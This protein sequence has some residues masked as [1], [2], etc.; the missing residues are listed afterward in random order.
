MLQLQKYVQGVLGISETVPAR[1]HFKDHQ[2]H[3]L[4]L[5]QEQ[6]LTMLTM[7]VEASDV[8]QGPLVTAAALA[9]S[10]WEDLQ[11]LRRCE[12]AGRD[13]H[14]LDKREDA[15]NFC[16]LPPAEEKLMTAQRGKGK[17][18]GKG[19]GFRS[20]QP[21][22]VAIPVVSAGSSPIGTLSHRTG[23]TIPAP[24]LGKGG[25]EKADPDLLSLPDQQCKREGALG[26]D[27]ICPGLDCTGV[28]L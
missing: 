20:F 6:V 25:R 21:Q 19:K 4:L 28:P 26:I 14:K 10:S 5:K 11:D 24:S 1:K 13:A 27:P 23:E 2:M 22:A 16:L 9:R 18:K 7:A 15:S 12:F 3:Q 8:Y 17:G